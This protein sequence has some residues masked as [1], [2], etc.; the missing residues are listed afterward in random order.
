[1]LYGA[2]SYIFTPVWNDDRLFLLDRAVGL[3]LHAVEI[4]VGDDVRFTPAYTRRWAEELG[5]KLTISPGG[6][7]P[8]ECD[9]S[10]PLPAERAR[11]QE[12]H[13]RQ[14][15]LAAE[16]GAL[17]YCGALYGHPGVVR[18][19]SNPAR[20]YDRIA[21]QLHLLADYAADQQ[22]AVVLEPMSHF[23]T[24]VANTP[25]QIMTLLDMAEQSNLYV[26]LDTYHMVTEVRDYAAAIRTVG[27]RLW[28]LHA[29]ENDRGA[30]GGGIVP[31]NAVFGAL[32]EIGFDGMILFETYNSSIGTFAYDR[33]MFHDVCPDGA[34]FVRRSLAF[35]RAGLQRF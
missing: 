10:S 31:W 20:E 17:A 12:W 34:E 19:G 29:C 9:L 1:M 3:G 33:G 28:A 15:D 21:E 25:E 4:G 32:R 16:L 18:R 14:I 5:L 8:L 27:E 2:H 6:A 11:G 22:V 30:P 13:R 26:L 23:R 7:W 35:V 24:H